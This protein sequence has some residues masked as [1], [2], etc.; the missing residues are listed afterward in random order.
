LPR[1]PEA[2]T[3]AKGIDAQNYVKGI[4]QLADTPIECPSQIVG[5][6][7]VSGHRKMHLSLLRRAKEASAF[8]LS[9]QDQLFRKVCANRELDAPAPTLE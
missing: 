6:S 4:L 7:F 2:M 5:D 9:C 1:F 8:I 3:V